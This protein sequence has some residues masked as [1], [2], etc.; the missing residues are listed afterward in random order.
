VPRRKY[1]YPVTTPEERQAL[2]ALQHGACAICGRDDLELF[3]DH[4]YRTG[5][6]RG[7]LCRQHNTALGMF[8]DSPTLLRAALRYLRNPPATQLKGKE[9]PCSGHV[10]PAMTLH[11]REPLVNHR[12]RISVVG[13]CERENGLW[14]SAA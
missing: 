6:T 12:D 1:P 2:E 11:R 7:L 4:S 14:G 10:S 13:S 9:M 5:K 3:A 8:R